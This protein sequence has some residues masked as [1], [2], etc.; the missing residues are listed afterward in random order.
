[1]AMQVREIMNRFVVAVRPDTP[2]LDVVNALRR[3][4]VDAVPVVDHEQRVTGMVCISDLL[5]KPGTRRINGGFFEVLGGGRLR[6]KANALT[7]EALMRT[8][9]VTVTEDST[10]KN[11]VALM[12]EN[13]VDQL[14]VVQPDG[15]LVGIVRRIDLLS[16]FCRRP[17]DIREEVLRVAERYAGRCE[18]AVHDG[19][20][21]ITGTVEDRSRVAELLR[22]ALAVDGVVDVACDLSFTADAPGERPALL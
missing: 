13:H 19:V 6:R 18:V 8:P 12:E 21:S 14:P 1:M 20:V 15:R 5:P 10:V 3:F 4:R 17:E 22:E 16:I 9:A 2:I 7:V 11:V